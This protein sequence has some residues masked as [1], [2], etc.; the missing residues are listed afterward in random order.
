MKV[1]KQVVRKKITSGSNK[2][3]RRHLEWFRTDDAEHTALQN[4]LN[5]ESLGAFVMRLSGIG[6]GAETRARRPRLRD[7]PA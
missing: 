2:R 3:R 4:R 7:P 5:G 6:S 1:A